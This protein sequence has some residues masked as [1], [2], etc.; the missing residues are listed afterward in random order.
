MKALEAKTCV[1]EAETHAFFNI[2][3][4]DD[5]ARAEELARGVQ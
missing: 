5:L 1:F 3:T 2:N 4:R